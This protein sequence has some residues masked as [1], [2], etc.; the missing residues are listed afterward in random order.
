MAEQLTLTTP[1][2]TPQ[3]VT[4]SYK[5]VHIG[6]WTVPTADVIVHLLSDIGDRIE[7]RAANDTEAL[8]LIQQLNTANLTIKSLQRRCLEWCAGKLPKLAGTVTGTPV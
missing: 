4:S 5:I 8:Q 6:L 2:I 7:V 1:D 3:I